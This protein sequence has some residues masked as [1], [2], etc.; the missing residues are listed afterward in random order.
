LFSFGET[1]R[2]PSVIID[3][4]G[5]DWFEVKEGETTIFRPVPPG[6]QVVARFQIDKW[7][8]IAEAAKR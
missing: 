8:R 3:A 7:P 1:T 5:K 2:P 6:F 4:F